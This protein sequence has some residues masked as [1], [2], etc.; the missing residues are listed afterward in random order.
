MADKKIS[1]LTASTTPLSGTEVLPI[2]QS[3]STVK[4]SVANLTAGRTVQ[5]SKLES[6]DGVNGRWVIEQGVNNNIQSA[7]TGFG[8]WK[9]ATLQANPSGL[10]MTWDTSGNTT[11]GV[12]NLIVG[13]AG[14]GV[15]LT[16]PDGLTTKLLRLSNLGAL[17]LV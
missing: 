13:T 6:D 5:V 10:N 4:V 14:K 8:N 17:E 2:V 16:S 15:T 7:T 3:G 1:A 11:V 9:T 12:G